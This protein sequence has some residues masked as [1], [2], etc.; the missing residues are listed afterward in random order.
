MRTRIKIRE[1]ERLLEFIGKI[2]DNSASFMIDVW[3]FKDGIIKAENKIWFSEYR[4]YLTVPGNYTDAKERL[5][6]YLREKG[7]VVEW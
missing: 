4:E 5:I 3:R 2:T 6:E 1:I 7:E